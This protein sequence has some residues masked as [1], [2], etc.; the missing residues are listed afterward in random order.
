[1]TYALRK[2]KDYL[3]L[4]ED[5]GHVCGSPK[6]SRT[7]VAFGTTLAALTTAATNSDDGSPADLTPANVWANRLLVSALANSTLLSLGDSS[8]SRTD[9]EMPD[10]LP[11]FQCSSSKYTSVSVREN[12]CRSYTARLSKSN[13]S[14]SES[15]ISTPEKMHTIIL[16]HCK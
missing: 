4:L 12:Q 6:L 15:E 13:S 8:T 7:A 1:M 3:L 9:D 2:F 16:F 5:V 11:L 14:D 10:D